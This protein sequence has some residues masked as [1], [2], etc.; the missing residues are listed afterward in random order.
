MVVVVVGRVV[1]GRVVM[2]RMG[3]EYLNGQGTVV[4]VSPTAGQGKSRASLD[5]ADAVTSLKLWGAERL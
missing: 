2:V 1:V 5:C 3:C 4:G